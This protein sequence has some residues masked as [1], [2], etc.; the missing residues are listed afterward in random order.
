MAIINA[1]HTPFYDP[2]DALTSAELTFIQDLSA[3]AS[4]DALNIPVI[5]TGS[6]APGT[7][8]ANEGD[9]YVDT[10]NGNAYIATG[11]ASSAD[12]EQIDGA[13]TSLTVA[14][15]DGT[16]SVSVTTLKFPNGTVTDNGDGSA[17]YTPAGSGGDVT[18]ASSFGTDNVLVRSD[19]VG[20]GVQASGITI[21]DTDAVSGVNG[22]TLDASSSVLFGA[23]TI[24][25]DS[26]GTTTLSNIDA[27]DATT[28]ATIEAAIDTLSNLTSV[29]TI[30]TGVWQGTAIGDSYISSATTWNA[31]IA[32]VVEDTTP[33]LGGELD[34]Q[35][36]NII[37]LADITFRTGA[38]GGTVRTGTSAADKFVLQAYD[39]D[40]AAYQTVLELDAGNTPVLQLRAD[41]LEID[42]QTDNS[43]RV[44]WDVSG[45]TTA[46]ATDLLFA[47]TA[48]R[49]ITFPDVTGTLLTELSQDT[50]PQ[51][52]GDL[53][54]NGNNIRIA[55]ANGLYF[56]TGNDL[57]MY[58][59][60][61]DH[62]ILGNNGNFLF[63]NS[64]VTA[65]YKF[66][67]G[68]DTS[69]TYFE[70]RN[71]T[72]TVLFSVDGD[73]TVTLPTGLT[74]VIRADSGVVSVD[75]DVTDI[76]TAA[77]TTA[78]GKIEV[79]TSAETNTGTDAT[80][81]VSPDGLA[82]SN[83]GIRYLAFTLN[84]STALTTSDIA[85]QRIPAAYSGMNLVSVTASVGT[86]AAGSSS[87]G[88]PTFTVKNVT[89]SNQM[90]STSLTVDA[91][92]YTSATAAAAAVINTATDDVV[93]DDLIEVACTVAGTGVT[94]ATITLGFQLP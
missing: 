71:N 89:D 25:S 19:G 83:L 1:R 32:N 66:T 17:T 41:F 63:D 77:S 12:W 69:A 91:N 9:I 26:A 48:N 94:F 11:A 55:D 87:S 78:A 15:L 75:T 81:A 60:G 54:S 51:L 92:E 27:L 49:S 62:Q 20:K 14:E 6:G 23:V 72:T 50:T 64:S 24:L 88:T 45:A 58:H 90:L 56:G 31:K 8:P 34:A 74:G 42:D 46:T 22:L 73:G 85:Y 21:S 2:E 30:G 67:L 33:Q 16:P 82:G 84:G 43:K 7:T 76:V 35:G 44:T 57:L 53:A 37:D 39:V 38:T 18:A 80:R 47:Q 36:N 40:G 4:D 10:S 93:T 70:V 52:G 5:S 28:E 79:A 61:S 29:G 86:G 68:T 3:G 65:G 59:D 13:G